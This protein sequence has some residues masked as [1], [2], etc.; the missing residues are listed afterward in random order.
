MM[1]VTAEIRA[2]ADHISDAVYLL[3]WR[4]GALC[5]PRAAKYN[6]QP[7]D[8]IG[9]LNFIARGPPG[10]G[11]GIQRIEGAA[12]SSNST[13]SQGKPFPFVRA[14]N[15]PIQLTAALSG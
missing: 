9:L 4:R 6:L 7:E 8:V 3:V 5:Q 2:T 10:T 11:L 1:R 14:Y 13:Y 15:Q 12:K